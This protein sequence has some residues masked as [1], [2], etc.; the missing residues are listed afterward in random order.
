MSDYSIQ[1]QSADSIYN[2]GRDLHLHKSE[3][4][5]QFLQNQ[6]QEELQQLNSIS[7]FDH[8]LD[9][10]SKK[11]LVEKAEEINL[12]TDLLRDNSQVL[13]YGPPGQGKTTLIY[14]FSKNRQD[15]I[16]CSFKGKSEL[17]L[18]SYLVNRIRLI[19][20][21]DLIQIENLE[22]AY[23]WLEVCVGNA[24]KFIVLDDC[25][26]DYESAKR[27]MSVHKGASRFIFVGRNKEAFDEIDIKSTFCTGLNDQEIGKF[28]E[29]NE[30]NVTVFQLD[31]I[32]RNSQGNPLYLYYLVHFPY[33]QLPSDLESF[34]RTIW[35]SLTQDQKEMTA[36][37]A[38]S[39]FTINLEQLSEVLEAASPIST[40][41]ATH[42]ISDIVIN[43]NGELSVFHP[44][45]QDYIIR[46]LIENQIH[47]TYAIRL[48]EY[49]LSKGF[50][51]R[52]T[53]LLLD[54]SPEK[55][56]DSLVDVCPYLVSVGELSFALKAIEVALK[57]IEPDLEKG[58]LLYQACLAYALLG[59]KDK[60]LEVIEKALPL[61][62]EYP[63]YYNSA[64]LFH[65]SSL[66]DKGQV[67]KGVSVMNKAL[68]NIETQSEKNQAPFLV[69]VAKIYVDVY[70]FSKAADASK[71]AYQF[72]EE[73]N[74]RQG[75]I[76]S[77]INLVTCLSQIESN[78]DTALIYGLKVLEII[79]S[80]TDYRAEM[81][82]R[83]AL[84]TIYRENEDFDNAKLHSLK[85][86]GL[87]QKHGFKNK[88]ILNYIN[89]ANIVRDEGKI[90]ECLKIYNEA[91]ALT[92]DG[93][94]EK[95]RGRIYWILSGIHRD[96]GEF[97]LSL[98]MADKALQA[99]QS[100]DFYF[101]AANALSEK[102]ETL[103]VMGDLLGSAE[104]L[105][106]AASYYRKIQH[107]TE[108]YQFALSNAIAIYWKLGMKDK[109]E[110][111]V[112]SFL[113]LS[114]GDLDYE[115]LVDDM[116]KY[117]SSETLAQNFHRLFEKYLKM[118]APKP[119]LIR[120]FL[121]F[122]SYCRKM[123]SGKGETEFRVLIDTLVGLL[124][125]HKYSYS[126]LAILIEQSGDL[127]DQVE[128]DR[129]V[130][131]ISEQVPFLAH[132]HM[133]EL[134]VFLS[135]VDGDINLE[136]QAF[137]DELIC[138]KLALSL[139][140]I[141]HESPQVISNIDFKQSFCKLMIWNYSDH[142][143]SHVGDLAAKYVEPLGKD[144]QSIHLREITFPYDERILVSLD[145]ERFN[146]VHSHLPGFSTLFFFNNALVSVKS[147]FS[148]TQIMGDEPRRAEI[149]KE[150]THLFDYQKGTDSST[151]KS[152]DYNVNV[153]ELWPDQS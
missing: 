68:D 19:E 20:G 97:D 38:L 103:E 94:S 41:E 118:P 23:R 120:Q 148:H 28:L 29:A 105:V 15:A 140:L 2:I 133:Q 100:V 83:N 57:F 108:S 111:M 6:K 122:L 70:E 86:I 124:G 104:S 54:I 107:F 151:W 66:V 79:D 89:Y 30:H 93:Q 142:V 92:S 139:I 4:V 121:M 44:A 62:A 84:A 51:V 8:L 85:A 136:M 137:D 128:F 135:T 18:L 88:A 45:F 98:S 76:N 24:S 130:N 80:K 123:D 147:H 114:I 40:L 109:A 115:D 34:Q 53:H 47:R 27:I 73:A 91:F 61:L 90:A 67:E 106:A 46:N 60:S 112:M 39:E 81:V 87:C 153:D 33:E 42:N 132:R 13:L 117:S 21:E 131:Q 3:E 119:N 37:V 59:D 69:T 31:K 152:G 141:I 12:L 127:L 11:Q 95:E 110:S 150:L 36:Y 50:L 125:Q 145:Y 63:E 10:F 9:H 14:Q 74:D 96:C 22:D 138:Q 56:K 143:K 26:Q 32:K 102:A 55:L 25:E 16:Y 113:Q 64:L 146:T 58:F 71:K 129:L 77:L 7:Y 126:I 149:F 1:N 43:N 35:S 78:K 134:V 116:F 49:Y 48:G 101:G 52:A 17:G 75:K 65:A 72:F 82:V 5:I 99:C 144:N